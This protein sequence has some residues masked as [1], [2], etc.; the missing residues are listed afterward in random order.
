M[1]FK[2]LIESNTWPPISTLFLEI[3]PEAEKNID[4]YK[5]V[6]EKLT[7]MDS[8]NTDMS[9]II[10]KERDDTDGEEYVEVSG[11]YNNPKNEEE[12]YSQGL[13]FTPCCK[14]LGMS[15]SKESLTIFSKEEIIIYCLYEMTYV[16]FSEED[17][18]MAINSVKNRRINRKSMTEEESN[19]ITAHVENYLRI[20]GEDDKAK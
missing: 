4:G 5:K 7:Q 3:Y 8:E 11:L 9:I 13:E 14:W 6:F 16:G 19:K 1:T 18:L 15:I 20:R 12:H 17:I 2:E 10:T